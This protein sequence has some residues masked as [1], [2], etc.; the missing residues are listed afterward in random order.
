MSRI[1]LKYQVTPEL[2]LKGDAYFA[3]TPSVM[4][5]GG[6][7]HANAEIGSLHAWADFTADFLV[8]WEP[9]H[10]DAR[11][12]VGIGAKWKCFH[13]TASTDLHIW[14][15]EFSGTASVDWFIFSFDVKFGP[16]TPN[17]PL[18]IPVAKFKKSFLQIDKDE[19][20]KNAILGIVA[21]SGVIGELNDQPIVTPAELVIGISSRIPIQSARLGADSAGITKTDLGVAPA[22]IADLG[23]SELRVS[24]K[25]VS[26]GAVAKKF[27]AMPV[28]SGFPPALWGK[29]LMTGQNEKPIQAVGGLELRPSKPPMV[30]ASA[31][32]TVGDLQFKHPRRYFQLVPALL[33]NTAPTPQELPIAD[34]QSLGLDDTS[35]LIWVKPVAGAGTAAVKQERLA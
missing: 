22:G 27:V 14:G 30:G 24:V 23:K 1:E 11:I 31:E 32:K 25:E 16:H 2:Y 6:G 12:H 18:P 7:L 28:K 26:G 33:V 19:D 10:Y 15:P 3:M 29:K 4:M 17:I 34:L 9:F 13:T 8:R 5:A 21:G 20:S 35:D